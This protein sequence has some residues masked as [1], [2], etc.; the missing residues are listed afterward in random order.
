MRI[1][2]V[3][4]TLTFMATGSITAIV[5]NTRALYPSF[6]NI[7]D[8]MVSMNTFLAGTAVCGL[9]YTSS[10]IVKGMDDVIKMSYSFGAEFLMGCTF[11]A[12]MALSNM[13]M[14]SATISFL[15]IRTWNPALMFVMGGA[16]GLSSPLFFLIKSNGSPNVSD[17]L[18]LPT[19]RVI[20][21]PLLL[22]SA[23]FGI[24]WGYVGVCPG[25]ALTN[26]FNTQSGYIPATFIL[27]MIA[28]FWTKE[29]L[30]DILPASR[31]TKAK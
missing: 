22:G 20:D 31:K 12:G 16:I 1:R 4:A 5:T 25:P 2:S 11:A 3:A 14:N 13:S 9:V 28:G 26:V 23:L 24:G 18:D 7:N 19:S 30:Y 8:M 6:E 29:I 15:D 17:K 27:S 10:L 21:F